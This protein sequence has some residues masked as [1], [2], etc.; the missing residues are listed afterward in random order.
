MKETNHLILF[1][2]ILLLCLSSALEGSN[3]EGKTELDW[4]GYFKL[5]MAR[6]SAVSSGGNYILYVRPHPE[7]ESI[8][9]LNITARQT[10]LGLNMNRGDVKGKLEVDFYGGSPEHK[11]ALMLRKAY[12]VVPLGPLFLEA[13]QT[14]DLISPLVPATINYSAVWGA[15][16]IGYRRPQV[17]LYQQSKNFIWD[18]FWGISLARNISGDLDGDTIVDGAASGVPAVQG[19]LAC[20]FR[21]G[22]ARLTLGGTAHYGRCNCPRED[23]SYANWSLGGDARLA[24][25]ARLSILGEFYTGEN[26]GQYGGAIY[27]S[28]T[29]GG[30]ESRGGWANVQYQLG[31]AWT[32]SAG[33][34]A[35]VV[36]EARLGGVSDARAHN[37]VVFANGLYEV[38]PG[39][40]LGFEWSKWT[41]K[42]VNVSPGSKRTPSDL[43]LQWAV[44]GNF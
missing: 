2:I 18:V 42:Y 34:G 30:L 7:G 44:Q 22:G 5:D 38:V 29:V 25:N 4:Y 15:G 24:V 37:S 31:Q 13:G 21:P 23:R 12:V 27:N 40:K 35:D 36:D 26:M 9:T 33:G 19:R 28:D 32:F 14:A 16:N 39:V 3:L 17:K 43:R 6:D 1:V 20:T 8:S 11:N 41:T 10:R